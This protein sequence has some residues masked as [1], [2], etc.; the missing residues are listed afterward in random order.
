LVR[1]IGDC[2]YLLPPLATPPDRVDE[3]IEVL[4]AVL[5]ETSAA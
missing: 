2:L 1:P 5:D 4:S 3:A